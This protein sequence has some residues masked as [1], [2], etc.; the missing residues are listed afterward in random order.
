VDEISAFDPGEPAREVAL[1]LLEAAALPRRLTR[2]RA[3]PTRL[4]THHWQVLLAIAV[5]GAAEPWG[6]GETP[7]G[8][9]SALALDLDDVY[10]VLDSLRREGLASIP[11]RDPDAQEAQQKWSLTRKGA[12]A[13]VEVSSFAGRVLRWP[14]APPP[15]LT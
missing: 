14:P 13:A 5:G 4:G 8:I 10:E 9:G 7:A 6:V 2:S 3:W 15:S 1:V 12:A 11:F